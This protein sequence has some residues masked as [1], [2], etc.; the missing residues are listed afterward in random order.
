MDTKNKIFVPNHAKLFTREGKKHTFWATIQKRLHFYNDA[1]KK[2]ELPEFT[3]PKTEYID[4]SKI[5]LSMESVVIGPKSTPIWD[6]KGSP[7]V[8]SMCKYRF[9]GYPI[10]TNCKITSRNGNN[11]GL[12]PIINGKLGLPVIGTV[13]SLTFEP[14][15]LISTNK[16]LFT[17][18]ALSVYD[19]GKYSENMAEA[20]YDAGCQPPEGVLK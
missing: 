1:T 15:D 8:D 20:L 6:G 19:A 2:W 16:M 18:W 3:P 14:L 17:R 13:T 11:I 10:F 7:P 9:Y 4:I 12:T 5:Y